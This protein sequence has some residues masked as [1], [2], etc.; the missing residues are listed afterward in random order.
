MK[1][2]LMAN[3]RP[4]KG[5]VIREGRQNPLENR[6]GNYASAAEIQRLLDS[7]YFANTN[8]GAQIRN[9]GKVVI[10]LTGE[11]P[12]KKKTEKRSIDFVDLSNEPP[13]R[14]QRTEVENVEIEQ[15]PPSWRQRTV[16]EMRT[17]A[18][19]MRA[20]RGCTPDPTHQNS[21]YGPHRVPKHRTSKAT[22]NV[23]LQA[24]AEAELREEI[25]CRGLSNVRVIYGPFGANPPFK[26]HPHQVRA[27]CLLLRPH[28]RGALLLYSVGSGK[29][30]TAI[31]C[32]DN[33][34]RHF[35]NR[36]AKTVVLV[37]AAM[38]ETWESELE[39]FAPLA[40]VGQI[41]IG[42]HH[43][44]DKLTVGEIREYCKNSILVVDEIHNARNSGGPRAKI[45]AAGGRVPGR[46]SSSVEHPFLIDPATLGPSST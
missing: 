15:E 18:Q 20:A 45:I 8:A 40:N 14:R 21:G 29:G 25:T 37:P 4:E 36:F 9:R 19:Y 34:R 3:R 1:G 7:G 24:Q 44:I 11:E 41:C 2:A 46:S 22:E 12:K 23:G 27:V 5:I 42:S 10:N 26:L 39:R 17:I 38:R 35:S 30:L 28:V 43:S 33:L 16:E 6:H 32:V 31:A 13:T